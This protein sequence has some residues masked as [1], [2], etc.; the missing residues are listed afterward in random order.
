MA[1]D[2]VRRAR[3]GTHRSLEQV[4][5][6]IEMLH[7][8]RCARSRC[9]RPQHR[10]GPSPAP[11]PDG[12][13]TMVVLDPVRDH[14]NRELLGAAAGL[15]GNVLAVTVEPPRHRTAR[16]VGRRRSRAPRRRQRRRRRRRARSPSS[17]DRERPWAILTPSTAWGREVASRAAARLDAGLDRRRGRPRRRRRPARRVE[18]R[19]R[20]PA[21]RRDRMHARPCRWQR[22]AP[23]CSRR[24]RR[25]LRTRSPHE[26]IALAGRGR[27]HVARPD[28]RRRHRRAR[29]SATR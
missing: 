8:S 1:V 6:A 9:G 18:A 28:A 16:R 2:R 23:A 29:R 25:A 12:P 26:T 3:R 19:V 10:S 21:R 20:R 11:R 22:C 17:S 13:C 7:A 27:V 5:D 14:T 24:S 4:D 15:T